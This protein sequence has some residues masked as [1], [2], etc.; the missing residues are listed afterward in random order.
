MGR[1]RSPSA[2]RKEA[3]ARACEINRAGHP[4]GGRPYLATLALAIALA[5]LPGPMNEAQAAASPRVTFKVSGDPAGLLYPGGLPQPIPLTLK[6]RMSKTIYITRIS[7]GIRDTGAAECD[8]SWFRTSALDV[9]RGGIAIPPHRSVSLARAGLDEPTVQMR[10]S[11]TNQDACRD[12]SLS[13]TYSGT[14]HPAAADA[15]ANA[16]DRGG[17]LPFTGLQLAL[18]AGA[19]ALLG[20]AGLLVRG[21]RA[22]RVGD[23]SI[24]RTRT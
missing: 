21:A 11:G 17:S 12:T 3:T 13:L 8:P 4:D 22:G 5:I 19:G 1:P 14:T 2:D 6:N 15:T 10:E 20:L 18:L 9:P 7:A 16:G 24:S 23:D